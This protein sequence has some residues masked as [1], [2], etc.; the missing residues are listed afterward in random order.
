M[1]FNTIRPHESVENSIHG[2]WAFLSGKT[3]LECDIGVS[4]EFNGVENVSQ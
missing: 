2:V 1:L 4:G 3:T